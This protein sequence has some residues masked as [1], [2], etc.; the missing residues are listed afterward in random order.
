[1]R[2]LVH[3]DQ[4]GPAPERRIEIELQHFDAPMADAA[5]RQELEPEHQRARF[6]ASVSLHETGDDV[7]LFPLHFGARDVEHRV[8]LADAWRGAEEDRE[9]P[10]PVRLLLFDDTPE[11]IV[12]IRALFGHTREAYVIGERRGRGSIAGR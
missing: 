12:W 8:G 2:E 5:A 7:A 6:V 11:Q 9:L 4:I 1:V 3:Q 10:P